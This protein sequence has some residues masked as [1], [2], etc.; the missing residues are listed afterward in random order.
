[1]KFNVSFILQSGSRRMNI[2]SPYGSGPVS[3]TV[4]SLRPGT[5]YAFKLF[6]VLDNVLSSGVNLTATTGKKAVSM[7]GYTHLSVAMDKL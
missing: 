4:L 3:F 2:L 1:M 6:S 7:K 5:Q